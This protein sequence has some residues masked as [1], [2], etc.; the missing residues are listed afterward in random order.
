M[1][2]F[3]LIDTDS[4]INIDLVANF[5]IE[6]EKAIVISYSGIEAPVKYEYKSKPARTMAMAKLTNFIRATQ[7]TVQ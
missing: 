6:G 1:S 7:K 5:H 4:Y 3:Y 2:H